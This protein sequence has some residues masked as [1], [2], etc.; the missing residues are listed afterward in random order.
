MKCTYLTLFCSVLY[1]CII[2]SSIKNRMVKYRKNTTT[3]LRNI[4]PL[5]IFLILYN[6]IKK[7]S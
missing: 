1:V 4:F 6:P 5:L 2:T 3:S 7:K